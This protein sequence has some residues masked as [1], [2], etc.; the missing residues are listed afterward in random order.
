MA[1]PKRKSV[2]EGLDPPLTYRHL[3]VQLYAP[4]Y[5]ICHPDQAKRVEG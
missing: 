3:S 1:A 4:N 2:G 5:Q